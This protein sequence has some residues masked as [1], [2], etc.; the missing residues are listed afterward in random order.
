MR[1]NDAVG[2]T[3]REIVVL[4]EDN[5]GRWLLR[6]RLAHAAVAHVV[7]DRFSVA[8]RGHVSASSHVLRHCFVER[9]GC[10]LLLFME[11]WHIAT[12]RREEM[13]GWGVGVSA[14]AC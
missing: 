8:C 5:V 2:L 12:C 9:S 6:H 10:C 3:Y 13:G 11:T 4:E 1:H 14:S 7:V